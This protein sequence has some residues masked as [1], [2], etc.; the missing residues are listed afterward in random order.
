MNKQAETIRSWAE[1]NFG[2]AHLS[3]ERRIERV[4][5][6]GEAMA[7]NAGQ[8]IPQMFA[9][10]YDVKAAYNLFK[11]EESTAENLQAGHREKVKSAM[12]ESG[13]YLLVE[14]TTAMSWSG[15]EPIP[16]LGPIGGG[17]AGLQGF[18]L[19]SVLAVGWQFESTEM[20]DVKRPPV[21]IIGIS[22]Q[23]S[24]VRKK[25]SEA[26]KKGSSY[27]RKRAPG[28][29]ESQ[30]WE[31]S[32]RELGEP[33]T[34][35]RYVH[36][37]D[38]EADIYEYLFASQ[39]QGHGYVVR[40]GQ[41]R[42][43]HNVERD[44]REGRLFEKARG[45]KELG[46]FKL[47]LRSRKG[48]SARTAALKVSSVR[49]LLSPPKSS[50]ASEPIECSIIRVWEENPPGGI[51]PLEWM[52]LSDCQVGVFEQALEC[53]LQYVTRWVIEEFHKALKTGLKAES[54]Q[55]EE[56]H[57][58]IAAIAIKSIVALRLIDL[59]ERVR[60]DEAQPAEES[61]LSKMELEVLRTTTEKPL[62][63]VKDV[64]LQIGRLGGHMNRK[65]DGMPGWITLWRGMEK[66][67]LLVEGVRIA[68]TFTK[69]G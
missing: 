29:R 69:F 37:A 3:D 11:H 5:T 2:A 51:E 40:A 53:V 52:L 31:D 55:L 58:L 68:H 20:E 30:R 10:T 41:N 1:D 35:V 63:T 42:A 64:A 23:K 22:H 49:V 39:E 50:Q 15:N 25:K 24:F 38:R 27:Q 65:A 44:G 14:D 9:S 4:V 57:R 17:S 26:K 12:T 43:L 66:L 16:G 61:S 21:K 45:A 33:E 62:K 54:L 7:V 60:I 8:T 19:H 48:E 67:R 34:G 6:I 28:E 32:V 36:V 18:F 46:S 13:V 47:R 56:G 59:K